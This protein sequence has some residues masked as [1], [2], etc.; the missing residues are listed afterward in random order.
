M[1]YENAFT[2]ARLGYSQAIGVVLFVSGMLGLLVIRFAFQ[3]RY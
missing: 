3:Q 1:V 2:S